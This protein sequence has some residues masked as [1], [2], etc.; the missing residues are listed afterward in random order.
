[1]WQYIFTNIIKPLIN[2]GKWEYT[3]KNSVNARNQKYVT[4]ID[5]N[6]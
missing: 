6:N 3:N 1:M 2:E 4:V 5:K